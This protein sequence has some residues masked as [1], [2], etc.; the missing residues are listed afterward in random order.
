MHASLIRGGVELSSYPAECVVAIEWRT[1]PGDD[2]TTVKHEL[3]DLAVSVTERFPGLRMTVE[4]GLSRAPFSAPPESRLVRTLLEQV[5]VGTGTPVVIRGEP[6]W[7]DCALLA[8]AG[9]PTALF[10]VA[11]GGAT[12]RLMGWT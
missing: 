1:I 9:I 3:D 10:G 12:Q 2:A 4:T 8:E 6:S 11:G 5:A 7:T